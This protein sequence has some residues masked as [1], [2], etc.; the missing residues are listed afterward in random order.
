MLTDEEISM[1]LNTYMYMDYREAD[2]GMTLNEILEELSFSED[3]KEGGIHYGEY[4]ILSEAAKNQEIGELVIGNQSHLMDFDTGTNA[5]TFMT[6]D[7]SN[8][9]VVYRG[10]GDGEWPDNGIGMTAVSTIQQERA[11]SYFETVVER[12]QIS[13]EQKLII[14]GHSKGG[15]KAQ[16]VTMS[17]G[18]DELVDVCYNIDGQGFS[19]IA[20]DNWKKRYGEERYDSRRSKITGIYG[21]NDYVNVLGNSIVPK[22]QVHYVKTPVKV[23]N[24]AGYHDIKYMFSSMEKDPATGELVTVFHGQKNCYVSEQGKLGGYASVLSAA[25]MGLEP[26]K[27]DGCAAT[28]MQMMELFGERKTGINDEKLT[29]SD[30]GDF[31]GTGVPLIAE[32][33]FFT[34]QGRD[35]LSKAFFK[36]SFSQDMNGNICLRVDYSGLLLQKQVLLNLAEQLKKYQEQV[37]DVSSKL[38]VF[39][40]NNWFLNRKIIGEAGK[41]EKEVK[42]LGKLSDQL[43]MIAEKYRETDVRTADDIE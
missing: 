1:L 17:T 14:T 40:K 41:L 10:T 9:Y 24:F 19:D 3:C 35:M 39:M 32:S 27:R 5:C 31:F 23:E 25:M 34:G 29:L 13:Q 42:E 2:D 28:M 21:E 26:D 30:I 11:L 7:G 36:K 15:N 22:E 16:Y 18:Y 33:L 8:I 4:T 12:E 37:E 43:G 20:V 38:P 6:K